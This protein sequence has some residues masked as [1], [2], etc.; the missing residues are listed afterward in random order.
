MASVSRKWFFAV[1][2]PSIGTCSFRNLGYE[3]GKTKPW[4]KQILRGFWG[5]Q[6]WNHQVSEGPIS[7]INRR[8]TWEEALQQNHP[9][10]QPHVSSPR[11][12]S[13]RIEAPQECHRHHRPLKTNSGV[14]WMLHGFGNVYFFSCRC[15]CFHACMWEHMKT[16]CT[17]E[18]WWTTCQTCSKGNVKYISTSIWSEN[19]AAIRAT[20]LVLDAKYSL[21]DIDTR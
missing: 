21:H 16:D 7:C 14:Q 11:K 9:F 13:C 10:G 6:L 19:S 18:H 1:A 12:G 8:V 3:S 20:H 4:H 17:K 5:F 15:S 2:Y